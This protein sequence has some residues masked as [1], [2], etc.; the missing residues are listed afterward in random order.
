MKPKVNT[1][2]LPHSPLI[3]NVS[4]QN[5]RSKVHHLFRIIVTIVERRAIKEVIVGNW[6][7]S[8]KIIES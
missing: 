4:S 5:G 8:V 1:E 6:Q 2:Q 3:R 7:S